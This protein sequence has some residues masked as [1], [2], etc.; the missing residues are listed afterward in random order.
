MK[1]KAIMA[2][3]IEGKDNTTKQWKENKGILNFLMS[4]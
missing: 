3:T 2:W 1:E 4:L